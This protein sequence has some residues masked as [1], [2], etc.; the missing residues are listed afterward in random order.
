MKKTLVV[1]LI[2]TLFV[3]KIFAQED[4]LSLRYAAEQ[5]YQEKKYQ[6][7]IDIYEKIMRIDKKINLVNFYGTACAFAQLGQKEKAWLYMNKALANGWCATGYLENEDR[8]TL[9][10]A[11]EQLW[12]I[13]LAESQ[14]NFIKINRYFSPVVSKEKFPNLIEFEQD[15]L[16]GFML[17][18]SNEIIIPA[19]FEIIYDVKN[20]IITVDYRG[21]TLHIVPYIGLREEK[22]RNE[23]DFD[24]VYPR[25]ERTG[26]TTSFQAQATKKGKGFDEK[27]GTIIA[28][29]KDYMY[30]KQLNINNEIYAIVRQKDA[31]AIIDKNGKAINPAFDFKS[32]GIYPV[33]IGKDKIV[34]SVVDAQNLKS[35]ITLEGKTTIKDAEV[36]EYIGRNN[37][38]AVKNKQYGVFDAEGSKVIEQKYDNLI[39]I[40]E[41]N[42]TNP[43]IL[44]YMG[45]DKQK[46]WIDEDGVEYRVEK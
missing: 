17:K 24:Q 29:S 46:F 19:M 33:D 8:L 41:K 30:L 10:K 35:L 45:K 9:L 12:K 28:Y 16:F 7:S 20:D 22:L 39:E 6:G 44:Y 27:M 1:L 15:S 37:F 11:D 42:T 21:V 34:F 43:F 25:D 18:G 3:Q 26:N 38:M 36:L 2:I 4:L 31:F 14:K 5:A 13:A 40:K 23:Y 32:S